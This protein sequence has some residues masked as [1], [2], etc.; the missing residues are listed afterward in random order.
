MT[1]LMAFKS[2]EQI[3]GLRYKI[4]KSALSKE[5]GWGRKER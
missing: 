1:I 5:T 4:P 3:T 2:T